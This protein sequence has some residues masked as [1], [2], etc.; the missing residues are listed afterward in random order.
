MIFWKD[1]L[2]QTKEANPPAPREIHF[3]LEDWQKRLSPELFAV[4]WQKSTQ[5]P[6]SAPSCP[7]FPAGLFVC[8]CCDA[9]LFD[10]SDKYES[11]SGWPSFT[12]PIHPWALRYE[13]D[14]TLSALRVEVLCN[15]CGAHL[16]HV[17][18]DGPAPSKL[19]FCINEISITSKDRSIYIGSIVLGGGCFWCTEAIF[20]QVIGV[21]AVESG[22][23]GGNTPH[24]TYDAVCSGQSDH[25]EVIRITYDRK[26][27]S[28]RDLVR[29][30][31]LTHDPTTP[32][33]QGHDI[34][35]QYRSIIFYTTPEE[36]ADA[37]AT[38]R[39][40]AEVYDQPIVTEVQATMPFYPAED[41]HQDY[42]AHNKEKAYCQHIISPK[43][44]KA[45]QVI[46]KL[47][48]RPVN[49]A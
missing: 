19:R 33:R 28:Y 5:A 23:A 39:Q 40:T 49:P 31:L 38:I 34:G 30:H 17:F 42:Y 45:R 16:G 48:N 9:L 37:K 27:L 41:Y 10:T 35:T 3:R 26:C 24:P 43:L 6:S 29:I 11:H 32:N 2:K 36:E 4:A 13:M 12:Q 46:Q 14:H 18:P 1:I 21:I 8:S 20:K 44:Q 22:Y 25:A 7:L 47:F 15:T